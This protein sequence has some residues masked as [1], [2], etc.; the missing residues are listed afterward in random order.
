LQRLPL[1]EIKI[2]KS[3]VQNLTGSA[4]SQAIVR[5]IM[6]L[7][8]TM[9]LRVVAEGMETQQQKE[10]L[11][12]LGCQRMQGYFIARPMELAAMERLHLEH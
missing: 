3:F 7:A 1:S 2:D 12:A 9:Q 6:A 10:V 5:A 11:L 4:G 8:N